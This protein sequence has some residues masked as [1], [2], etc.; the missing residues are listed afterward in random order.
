MG[1]E[2]K[3]ERGKGVRFVLVVLGGE[4][5]GFLFVCWVGKEAAVKVKE[6]N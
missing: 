2:V 5:S 3:K 1:S 4:F 6:G